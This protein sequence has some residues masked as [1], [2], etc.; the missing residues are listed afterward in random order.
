MKIIALIPVY[1]PTNKE[2]ENVYKLIEEVDEIIVLDD[3]GKSNKELFEKKSDSCR[4]IYYQN[5]NNFGLTASVNNGFKMARKLGADWILVMN[6]DGYFE[7]GSVNNF[8]NLINSCA[9][10]RVAIIAPRYNLERRKRKAGSGSK[11]IKYPDMAGSLYN[12]RVL[13]T[14]GY[15]DPKTYFYG[16]D[17]EYCIRARKAGYKII[18]CSSALLNH[19]P[20]VNYEV[21]LLGH[22]VFSCGKD[23]PQRYYYQFRS[24]YYI[25]KKYHNFH[26]WFSGVAKLLKVILFFDNKKE[27]FKMIKLGIYD[28]K[29]GFY[30]NINDREENRKK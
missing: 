24:K 22:K 30:G 5:E 9:C 19:N 23:T 15:Y 13:E 8:R 16:L 10:D 1:M 12:V 7:K 6:P 14:I 25:Y 2:A 27:Y 17:T 29:Q 3:S 26:S 20:A 28:A 4:L 21:A 11:Q 18:E